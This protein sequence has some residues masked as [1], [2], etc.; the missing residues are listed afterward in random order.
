MNAMHILWFL[1]IGLAA[2]FLAG[3][4]MKGRGFGFVGNLVVGVVGAVLGG[5][6]FG[7]IGLQSTSLIGSLA[8]ALVGAIVFLVLVSFIKRKA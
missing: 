8:T 7:L 4:I 5:F 2:G 1:L 3:L 6:L